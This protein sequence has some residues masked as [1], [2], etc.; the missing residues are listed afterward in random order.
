MAPP[1]ALPVILA[2]SLP[3]F[4]SLGLAPLLAAVHNPN[5]NISRLTVRVVSFDG[6]TSPLTF[7]LAAGVASLMSS[8]APVPNFQVVSP[9]EAG[10]TSPQDLRD[11][12]TNSDV[13]GAVYAV[14]GSAASL[15]T[16]LNASLPYT[17]SP[18]IYVVYD[19]ARNNLVTPRVAAA[20]RTFA[21]TVAGRV[22]SGALAGIAASPGGG[23]ALAALGNARPA[24]LVSAVTVAEVNIAPFDVPVMTMAQLLG[25]I[26]MC[27]FGMVIA[28]VALGPLQF[29]TAKLSPGRKLGAR[30][31]AIFVYA[32]TVS[33][34]FATIVVGLGNAAATGREGHYTGDG[35]TWAQMWTTFWLLL[36][37][38]AFFFTAIGLFLAPPAIAPFL[39]LVLLYN[40]LGGF[41]TDL[42]DTGYR[43]FWY[44]PVYHAAIVVRSVMFGSQTALVS[45]SVG[46]LF[47]WLF[48]DIGLFVVASR[49][50]E[51]KAARQKAAAAAVSSTAGPAAVAAGKTAAGEEGEEGEKASQGK[52]EDE[53][54][55]PVVVALSPSP[56]PTA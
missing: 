36:S 31:L 23:A 10:S 54:E 13:W 18:S 24:A 22:T 6:P 19:E 26:L 42:A 56:A 38:M 47:L 12:V 40:V 32:M 34:A 1:K 35:Q 50:N 52:G 15:A 5:D 17:A 9:T 51:A 49:V 7:G 21:A 55:K 14:S 3:I 30:A 11:A 28:N 53:D 2:V 20:M 41:Q 27:V 29:F 45:R 33:A 8:G 16:A 46:I 25:N 39:L 44:A 48:V 37:L 4:F 43:F